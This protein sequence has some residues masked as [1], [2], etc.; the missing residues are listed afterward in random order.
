MRRQASIPRPLGFSSLRLLAG[1]HWLALTQ[2]SPDRD[3][4][5]QDVALDQTLDAAA[6]ATRAA[7]DRYNR[8]F[9]SAVSFANL[10]G[11]HFQRN[12]D[13]IELSGFED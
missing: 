13:A 4:P 2:S 1:L 8:N 11:S 10:D 5:P 6:A 7:I 9:D 3:A 12:L